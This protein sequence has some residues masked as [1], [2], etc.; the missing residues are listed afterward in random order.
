M[1]NGSASG[2]GTPSGT[3]SWHAGVLA[4]LREFGPAIGLILVL[5]VFTAIAGQKMWSTQTMSA[6]S[7]VAST[8]AIVAVGVTLLMI[9]GEFDLSVGQ[10]FAFTP[11]VWTTL[12]VT[13]GMNEWLALAIAL[14]CAAIVGV[15]NGWVTTHFRIP[16]FITTLG[17]FFVL[18]GLNNLLISGRQLIAFEEY[19]SLDLLGAKLPGTP[20]YLPLICMF[21]IATI[22]WFVLTRTLIG[23]WTYATGGKVGPAKAMG[24]PTDR[25]KRIN[26]IACS[27]LAG[28]AGCMQFAYVR[29]ITQGQG[30]KY[31]LFAITAA[32]IGGTSLFGGVGTIWGSIIGAFLL[33]TIQIGLV[34]SGAPGSFYVTFIGL[35]LVIV[36]I[37]N[38][39]LARSGGRQA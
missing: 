2:G 11:I 31:E 21:L 20:F 4:R 35:M 17:M 39:R 12:F 18:Q 22:A 7:T 6:I 16:S 38:V 14:G 8:V 29:G 28:L 5:L 30:D 34:L 10:N 13:N 32:V 26:F 1:T 27:F 24:V 25:V 23:N 36:V 37:A 15:V 3:G 33:A 19:P 9:C